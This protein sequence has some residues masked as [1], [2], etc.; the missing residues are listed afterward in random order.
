MVIQ[1]T[2][3]FLLKETFILPP[4]LKAGFG[5]RF[6]ICYTLLKRSNQK[7]RH[8]FVLYKI[9]KK[10]NVKKC[11]IIF[12]PQNRHLIRAKIA[13]KFSTPLLEQILA[14][15]MSSWANPWSKGLLRSSFHF[16]LSMKWYNWIFY[17]KFWWFHEIL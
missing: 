12:F 14:F 3:P 1:R 9:S 17:V 11:V 5:N 4:P 2:N 16:M 6:F 8:G 15:E 13:R 10:W 7:F